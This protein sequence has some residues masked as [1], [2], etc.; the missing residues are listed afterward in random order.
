MT[1]REMT[2]QGTQVLV[3]RE[4]LR[5]KAYK[6]SVGVWTI[7]VGHTSAA[8]PPEVT[9]GMVITEEE[10]FEIFDRD[11]DMFEKVIDDTVTVRLNNSQFDALVSFVFNIGETQW[12]SSTM[13]KK[14]NA[15]DYEGAFE[16]FKQWKKPPEI[17]PR[18]RGEAACFGYALYVAR[19]EDDSE[20]L[21]DYKSGELG[22][23]ASG[24]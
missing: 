8:G 3:D 6:D 18:R 17:I 9:S 2:D 10:A 13:L 14:L 4:G 22:D 19:I 11:N 15:G 1:H 20:L 12:R 24:P 16:Q 21:G 5:T 7:G 23:P